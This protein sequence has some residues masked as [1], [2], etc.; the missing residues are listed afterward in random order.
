MKPDFFLRKLPNVRIGLGARPGARIRKDSHRHCHNYIHTILH[1]A[2]THEH[3]GQFSLASIPSQTN[4]IT[5]LPVSWFHLFP[6]TSQFHLLPFTSTRINLIRL[7]VPLSFLPQEPPHILTNYH[8]PSVYHR[9]D[10]FQ[11]MPYTPRHP[12]SPLTSHPSHR[13]T[14]IQRSSST[15]SCSS[16]C[17]ATSSSLFSRGSNHPSP[18]RHSGIKTIVHTVI[19]AF[20]PTPRKVITV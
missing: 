8:T 1:I 19:L 7:P 10:Y 5:S 17:V 20:G 14:Q 13:Q 16:I 9:Q 4:T 6:P 3:T 2:Y 11:Y 18:A 15:Q 12:F